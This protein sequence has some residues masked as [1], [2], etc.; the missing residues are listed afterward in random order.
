M[1]LQAV[2]LREQRDPAGGCLRGLGVWNQMF[3]NSL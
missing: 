1:F 2:C 3:S